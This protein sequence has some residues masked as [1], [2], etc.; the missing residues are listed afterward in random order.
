M[1]VAR[2]SASQHASQPH[3]LA[4]AGTLSVRE[5]SKRYPGGLLANDGITLEIRSGE[6]F[7]LL[8]PNGAGK[9]TL[10]KQIIG[11]LRPTS[12]QISLDGYDLVRDPAQ[13][14]QLVTYLPQSSLPIDSLTLRQVVGLVGRIRGGDRAMVHRRATEM[15]EA[16]ELVPW[17]D[18]LGI[19]LSGGVKRLVGFVMASVWPAS[20]VILDE[21]TNDVDPLRRRLLWQQIR[22]L[23]RQGVSV[24]LVTH[25][26]LEAEQSVDRLAVIDEGRI[27][28]QGTPSSLK[29]PD[30]RCLRLRVNL[31]PGVE[32]PEIPQICRHHTLVGRR[33]HLLIDE[34]DAGDAIQWA[35]ASIEHGIAEEYALGAAT[36]EDVYIRLIGRDDAL[37]MMVDRRGD[38]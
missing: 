31:I 26:V 23:G 12:G 33:L 24:L 30:R 28:A 18:S 22:R 6:V 4:G 17:A 32:K 38:A 34:T 20:L 14:R 37:E 13:A 16:L 1:S 3:S 7:G 35:R 10:V 11:L 27:I 9:T 5:L 36:L 15:I 29:A 19:K 8:G 25:N 21:P 2:Q